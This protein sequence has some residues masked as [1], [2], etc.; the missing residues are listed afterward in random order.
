MSNRPIGPLGSVPDDAVWD[1]GIAPVVEILRAAGVETFESCEGGAGHAFH[2][3]TVRFYG[4]RSAGFRAL[5]VA[6]ENGLRVTALRRYWTVLD[7]E[8][9]GPHWELE[10]SPVRPDEES[11]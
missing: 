1:A 10:F 11:C 2:V 9:V 5:A 8:P 4:G 3:P 6:Q 7:G